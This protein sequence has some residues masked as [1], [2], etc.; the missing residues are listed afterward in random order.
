MEEL[1]GVGG[2]G[3]VGDL[4]MVIVNLGMEM[5][6]FFQVGIDMVI[7]KLKVCWDNFLQWLSLVEF[8]Q[9]DYIF[10]IIFVGIV[11]VFVVLVIVIVVV[12]IRK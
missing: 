5:Y 2:G 1:V 7:F 6:W 4:V 8:Q 9:E 11:I 10:E 12:V 3:M